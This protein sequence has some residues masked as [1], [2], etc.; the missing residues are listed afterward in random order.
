M[1]SGKGIAHGTGTPIPT[2]SQGDIVVT[3]NLGNHKGAGVRKAIKEEGALRSLVSTALDRFCSHT[4]SGACM[5][6][7][8]NGK[9]PPN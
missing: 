2:L 8:G 4:T 5:I 7:M 9:R 6:L 1:P 3:D